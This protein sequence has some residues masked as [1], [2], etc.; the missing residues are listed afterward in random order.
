MEA[1]IA[2]VVLSRSRSGFTIVVSNVATTLKLYLQDDV[3]VF[4]NNYWVVF[5]V[6]FLLPLGTDVR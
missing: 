3:G 4:R 6:N 5:M 1:N 2:A